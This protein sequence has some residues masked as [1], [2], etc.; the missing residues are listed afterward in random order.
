MAEQIEVFALPDVGE[1][2]TE[3]EILT[4][5]VQP[6]DVVTVNQTIVEIETAKAAVELPCPFAGTVVEV[7]AAPGSV[8]PVGAPI[9]SIRVESKVPEREAVL[10]GYGVRH[11][12]PQRR[13]RK[14]SSNGATSNGSSANGHMGDVKVKPLVRKL[15]KDL[16]VDLGTITGTGANGDITREDILASINEGPSAPAE[17]VTVAVR[18]DE[19]I[20]VRG[21]QKSMAEAMVL[22]AFSAPH[23]TIWVEVEMT[24]TLELVRRMR[25]HPTFKDLRVT[26]LTIASA[27]IIRSALQHP[28]INATWTES[29]QG[30]DVIQHTQVHLGIAADT[31]R[32]LLVPVVKHASSMSLEQLARS[33]KS[34][35]ETARSGRSSPADLTGSTITVT[36]VGVFGVD[37]GT[38]IINPGESAIVA[39]GRIIDKPWV[40]DGSVQV[41]PVMTLSLSFDHRVCDGAQ[42]SRA[43][44]SIA[45]FLADPAVELLL[46]A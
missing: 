28:R 22:S 44:V 27:A 10:V 34:L 42:G 45:D 41:R 11:D 33:Q 2:L 25:E 32:G 40:V 14:A 12:A 8:V 1:G 38:P 4:W 16:G 39:M 5:H 36:N 9:I 24:R 35:I 13:P 30:A 29:S 21:V 31:P 46:D 17:P 43:L 18:G 3:G 15:A 23:V 19:R 20:P 6:G 7:H 26:P 37:G